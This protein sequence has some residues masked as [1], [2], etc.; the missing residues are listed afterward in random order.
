ML[1][2]SRLQYCAPHRAHCHAACFVWQHEQAESPITFLWP[3]LPSLPSPLSATA[4][5]S[6]AAT[7]TVSRSSQTT[8]HRSSS[9]SSS[10]HAATAVPVPPRCSHCSSHRAATAVPRS[11]TAVPPRSSRRAATAIPS[12]SRAATAAP[13]RVRTSTATAV[14]P[15]LPHHAATAGHASSH[16]PPFS[17]DEF[18]VSSGEQRCR[19]GPEDRTLVATMGRATRCGSGSG[20]W[21]LS[22]WLRTA[23]GRRRRVLVPSRR[24]G[25][26]R[27][28]AADRGAA[29]AAQG[30]AARAAGGRRLSQVRRPRVPRQDVLQLAR[31]QGGAV[32]FE[33]HVLFP[34]RGGPDVEPALD[35]LA[36]G[37][38]CLLP[39]RRPVP[40]VHGG[41]RRRH[42]RREGAAED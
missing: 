19:P 11:S 4:A 3:P 6:R 38:P 16:C 26:G 9:S 1:W 7:A 35:L 42:L 29:A 17:H 24:G 2:Q 25:R 20:R 31:G 22:V 14:P 13:P 18:A 32:A 40:S 34:V 33:E 15:H 36:V 30:P 10:H 21:V 39:R 27:P 28:V 41:P 12:R 5:P 23:S 8:S 37:I